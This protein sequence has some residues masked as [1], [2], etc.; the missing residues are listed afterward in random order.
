MLLKRNMNNI[1]INNK[2]TD[3]RGT[4]YTI[5]DS[6]KIDIKFVQ[7]KITKSYKG[8]IRGF[9]GD[10]KTYKLISCLHGKIKLVTY[11]VD[12]KIKEEYILDA[13]DPECVSVLVPPRC[14]NAH[15]CLSKNCI[16]HYKWSE[17]YT[18][19]EDQW[20]VS[21][22]DTEIGAGWDLSIPIIQSERDIQAQPL[23]QLKK[24]I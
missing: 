9:H 15:Q 17:Y 19:P 3:N 16:F 1:Y 4:I 10:A 5:Y 18:C 6:S 24:L 22:N 8:V 14:L 11:N 2:F 13:N 21:Y 7:D 23:Q 12:T 20:T